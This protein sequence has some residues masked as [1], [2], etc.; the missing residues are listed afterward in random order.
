MGYKLPFARGRG[1]CPV[2]LLMTNWEDVSM[3]NRQSREYVISYVTYASHGFLW[4]FMV[5]HSFSCFSW[6]L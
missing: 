1:G 4:F 3:E 2:L 5:S 6:L